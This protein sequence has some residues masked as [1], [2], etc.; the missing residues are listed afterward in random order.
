M[1]PQH[2]DIDPPANHIRPDRKRRI[3]RL[4]FDDSFST[5][6]STSSEESV[7]SWEMLNRNINLSATI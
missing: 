1:K 7:D 4:P 2:N 3:K 6:S 5:S